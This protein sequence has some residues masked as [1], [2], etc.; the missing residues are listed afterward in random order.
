MTIKLNDRMQ[1]L[2]AKEAFNESQVSF[3]EASSEFTPAIV[4]IDSLIASGAEAD[5]LNAMTE[6]KNM[7]NEG[8]DIKITLVEAYNAVSRSIAMMQEYK[9]S[10][11][12]PI[13][14]A[15]IGGNPRL[16]PGRGCQPGGCREGEENDHPGMPLKS[17]RVL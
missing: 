15:E 5:L 8:N 6:A 13:R 14:K 7:M 1:T 9:D 17:P 2:A 12:D 4:D 11:V 10:A 3:M 16:A